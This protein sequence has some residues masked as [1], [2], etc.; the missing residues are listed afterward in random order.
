MAKYMKLM[1]AIAFMIVSSLYIVYDDATTP[2][3]PEAFSTTSVLE[4]T[5]SSG[6]A[7]SYN[8]QV[9]LLA[10]AIHAEAEAEPY[11]GKVAVGAVLLNRVKKTPS[12]PNTLSGVIYQS[13]AL[14]SVSNGR[15]NSNA[16]QQS[17]KAA[18]AALNGWGSHLWFPFTFGIPIKSKQMGLDQRN[19]SSIRPTCFRKIRG[20][21]MNKNFV[22]LFLS[23]L[24]VIGFLVGDFSK[25]QNQMKAATL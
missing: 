10:R 23:V 7:M 19:Y 13:S 18:Q 14:E 4:Y 12:S 5:A 9:T 3:D 17:R 16:G 20:D 8:D 1:V 11:I 6:N 25:Q 2:S 22:I 24:T 15:M 21:I